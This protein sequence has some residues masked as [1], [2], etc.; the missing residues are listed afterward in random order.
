MGERTV[1]K[2]GGEFKRVVPSNIKGTE[3]P[4]VVQQV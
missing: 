1:R 3:V 4:I 2:E